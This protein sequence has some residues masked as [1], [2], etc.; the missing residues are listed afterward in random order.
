MKTS[1]LIPTYNSARTI[2]ATLDSVFSQTVP[3]D[4]ILIMDDGST[5]STVS[6]LSRYVPR[7]TLFQQKN[8]GVAQARNVL[9]ERARGDL[10]AFLDH[11]DIW[12]PTYLATQ[13]K[14]FGDHQRAAAFF[15]AHDNH[16]GLGDYEWEPGRSEAQDCVEVI[17]ALDFIRQ[18]HRAIGKFAS[19]SFCCI[20][21]N[22][23]RQLGREPFC[24]EVSGVD[25]FYLFHTL[26]L[27][28]PII[29]NPKPL[30]AYRITPGAQSASLLKSVAKAVRALELLEDRFKAQPDS[31]LRRSFDAFFSAQRREYG[32]VLMGTGQP[33]EARRQLRM[34]LTQS[35][36]PISLAKSLVWLFL[37]GVPNR[38][39]PRWPSE[40]KVSHSGPS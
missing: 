38:F 32:R 13:L 2:E 11:D 7:I 6:L 33:D 26:M 23:M 1:V 8:R 3:P 34:S 10:I 9:S 21:K 24:P 40:W 39:Q 25:D 29:F 12:H 35:C 31:R 28:G 17:A 16:F 20:P 5:D 22:V 30:V 15:T 36:R 37:T 27:H 19:M 4:E 18:Y 14:M